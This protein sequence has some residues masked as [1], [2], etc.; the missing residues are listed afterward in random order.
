[1][2][3]I[4]RWVER[5]GDVVQIRRNTT[6]VLLNGAPSTAEIIRSEL[7]ERSGFEPTIEI[8]SDPRET[9]LGEEAYRLS[10]EGNEI[11]VTGGGPAGTFYGAQTLLQI[12]DRGDVGQDDARR[13]GAVRGGSEVETPVRLV[14]DSP[15]FRWRGLHLDV[16]RHFFPVECIKEAI[17]GC[18][19][20]KLNVFHWHLTDDQGWRF[21]VSRR[22][23]LTSVGAWRT[24]ADGSVH[25]GFYN[26]EEIRAIVKYASE[27]FVTIVPEI[28]MPGHARAALA[29]YPEVSCTGAGLPVPPDWGIFDDVFCAGKEET[30]ELLSDVLESVAGL[31][32][33]PFIHIGGDECPKRRW[34]ECP[35]CQARMRRE[36]IGSAEELQGWFT[37]RVGRILAGLGKRMIG[38]GE[39]LEGGAPSDAAIM[40]WR[41]TAAG[42]EGARR[43]HDVIMTPTAHCYL[44][45]YQ[46]PREEEPRAFPADLPLESVYAFEPVPVGIEAYA[47]RVLGGQANV[48]TERMPD[49]PH[50]QY[51]LFPRLCAMAEAL[52]SARERRNYDSFLVRM[53]RHE[54]VLAREGVRYRPIGRAGG[55][56]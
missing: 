32:P 6:I 53:R 49:W 24:L 25:G 1:M 31:F 28:E 10:V 47:D 21:P 41:G 37:A 14:M 17:R 12:L 36:Q 8:R 40:S 22:S 51:M 26:P 39:I 45:Y 23:R 34:R 42:E 19:S 5:G 7:R 29:A 43:G 38:W 27:R 3:P 16:S 44:D 52:W 55:A 18:A 50:V 33:G 9:D 11:R 2:I 54:T 46:G 30:F 4:P 15:R 13:G 20:L 56:P 35:D 48:W